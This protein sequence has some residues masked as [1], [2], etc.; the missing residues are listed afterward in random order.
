MWLACVA[1]GCMHETIRM[2]PPSQRIGAAERI[3]RRMLGPLDAV[4]SRA[5]RLASRVGLAAID[6][7]LDSRF[8]EEAVDRVLR[9]A[10]AE[11]ALRQAL[12]GA[13]IDVAGQDIA[14]RAVIE[15]ISE[16]LVASGEL[17][18]IVDSVLSSPAAERMVVRLIDSPLLDEAVARLLES[19]ELWLL[20]DE[21]ARSPAVTEAISKQGISFADQV[22]GAVRTR[23]LNA[24][25]R[26]ELAVRG[27]VTRRRKPRQAQ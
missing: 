2:R 3:A 7:A 16:P 9:S 15:R 14:R 18:R 23:S 11:R 21:I 24:D 20:V 19:E 12:A 5:S 13:L 4:V 10:L 8:A 1:W 6:A 27:L 17:D 26:L 22:A 25:D